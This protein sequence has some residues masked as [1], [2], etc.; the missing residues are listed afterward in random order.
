V[1]VS[2]PPD[3][4]PATA[5]WRYAA[6]LAAVT[7]VHAPDTA[8]A[9]YARA[10]WHTLPG[11]RTADSDTGSSARL[12]WSFTYDEHGAL[13]VLADD[14]VCLVRTLAATQR[15][16]DHEASA[17]SLNSIADQLTQQFAQ[18]RAENPTAV[19]L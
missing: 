13:H 12:D 4:A 8:P 3:G 18:H 14:V 19:A 5:D 7:A 1:T 6:L 17:D 11:P 15:S 2:F 16:T 9:D 10:A